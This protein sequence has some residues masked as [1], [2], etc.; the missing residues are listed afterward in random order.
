MKTV[1]AKNE[2]R[3]IHKVTVVKDEFDPWK[4]VPYGQTHPDAV[5]EYPSWQDKQQVQAIA[6]EWEANIIWA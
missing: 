5:H 3:N 1:I 6:A 2:G 4:T